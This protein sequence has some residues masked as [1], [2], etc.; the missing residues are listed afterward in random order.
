M[1]Q[2]LSEATSPSKKQCINEAN[3]PKSSVSIDH[4]L[5]FPIA[6]RGGKACLIKI[7]EN[8]DQLKLNDVCEFIGFLAI[9]PYLGFNTKEMEDWESEVEMQTHNPSPSLVPRVHCVSW[10]IMEHN[11]PLV[12][13][14][15]LGVEKIGDLKKEVLVILTQLLFGDE[16]AAEYLLYHLISSVYSRV[17]FTA[18]GKFTLNLSCIPVERIKNYGEVFYKFLE[19]FVPKSHYLPMSLNNMNELPFIP[20]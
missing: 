12:K 10:R 1:E 9:D 4:I 13:E 3:N 14:F 7:Y 20:K 18:L 2:N 6:E 15:N 11:N 19:L 8:S 16:L 5:N 17:D